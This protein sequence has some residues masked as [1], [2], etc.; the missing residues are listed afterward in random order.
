[1]VASSMSFRSLAVPKSSHV[2]FGTEI[3]N[4]NLENLSGK[5]VW[6]NVSH[7]CVD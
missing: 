7:R 6:N 4:V 3:T 1:M 2:N 5:L